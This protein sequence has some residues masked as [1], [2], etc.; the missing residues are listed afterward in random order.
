M[1]AVRFWAR[2]IWGPQWDAERRA[3]LVKHY[4]THV[5][6]GPV[7]PE[8]LPE[9]ADGAAAERAFSDAYRRRIEAVQAR[10][11]EASGVRLTYRPIGKNLRLLATAVRDHVDR[12]RATVILPDGPITEM[13]ALAARGKAWHPWL[14]SRGRDDGDD[15]GRR[16]AAAAW[17]RLFERPSREPSA[18]VAPRDLPQLPANGTFDGEGLAHVLKLAAAT[19]HVFS[20]VDSL[21]ASVAS[22]RDAMGWPSAGTPVLG[23][24]VRRGDAASSE[25]NGPRRSTRA[26]FPLSHYLDAADRLC[27]R[28][29]IRHVFLAT[30]SA[31]EVA[32]AAAARPEYTF[33]AVPHDRSSFPDIAT[34]G[35][36]IEEWS[37]DEPSLAATLAEAAIVDLAMFGECAA[38]VGAFNS[39]FSVLAWLLAVGGRGSVVPY[40]SL[41]RPGR[42]LRLH[43]FEALLNLRNNCP[44]ELYHW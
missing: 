18:G 3:L 13:R 29:G 25:P 14:W 31:D 33:L 34:S 41:S 39:E 11:D 27:G 23:M 4:W 22:A 28:Y 2:D 10:A 24:H 15:A 7:P 1:G 42:S 43:P 8:H 35:R 40:V 20:P 9:Q 30:E 37:L 5:M 6:R 32:R 19:R 21:R 26:S 44:L 36:F 17:H 38:F 16:D 12:G